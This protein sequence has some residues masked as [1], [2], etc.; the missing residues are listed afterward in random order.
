MHVSPPSLH[1]PVVVLPEHKAAI[2]EAFALIAKGRGRKVNISGVPPDILQIPL[3]TVS[4][5]TSFDAYVEVELKGPGASTPIQLL[6][7]SGNSVL[8]LPRFEDIAA[9]P[10]ASTD[11]HVLG[12]SLEP[13]ECPAN[14]VRGPI[15][16]TTSSGEIFTIADCVF[17]ACTGD[18]P[19][20]GGRTANFGAG[21]LSP[22]TASGWNCP[23]RLGVTLQA[24]LSYNPTYPCAE[25]N[26]APAQTI[27]SLDRSLLVA[28]GSYLT[29]YKAAPVGYRLFKIIGD[30][31]WMS[32]TAKALSIG[33]VLTEWP[34]ADSNPLAVIDT[35]G[36]SVFLTDP[37][38]RVCNEIWP[39]Q[40][41]N[42]GWTSTSRSCQSTG[43]DITLSIGD[44]VETFRYKI[45]TSTLP[46]TVQGL[47]LVMCIENAF[48]MGQNGMNIGG[49]SALFNY[50]LIDYGKAHVG[51]R[52]K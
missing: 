41:A 7:D 27:F 3:T 35:G 37:N 20:T 23:P 36:T 32:L 47:T 21:C 28:S 16:I 15:Q 12:A 2:E 1:P 22:W 43:E 46:A 45:D 44:D 11:Y 9:L 24:P 39:D 14:V 6:V 17:Y 31:E 51:L 19:R 30:L 8:I 25:F 38:G 18:S 34:G 40:V 49:I 5:N 29:L 26:Y 50:I 33:T 10:N 13:W 52:P 4:L 48:M 42:P